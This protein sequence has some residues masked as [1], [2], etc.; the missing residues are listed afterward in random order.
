MSLLDSIRH[1]WNA[2]VGR[3]PTK[4]W[5][6]DNGE[7]SYTN[8]GRIVLT[9]GN[10]RSIITAVY[11]R[12]AVDA[13][14]ID[15]KH[16]KADEDGHFKSYI[17]DS[18]LNYLLEKSANLDQTGR[19]FRQSLFMQIL[20]DGVGVAV[21]VRTKE[22]PDITTGFKIEELRTGKITQWYP[23]RVKVE[24][25]DEEDG[26]KKEVIVDKK[27]TT[28]VEN[29]FYAIMNEKNSTLQRLIR[30]LNLLDIV[31]EASS[32]GK[33]DMIIQL[34]YAVK[35]ELQ[36]Q[37]AEE[38]TK[39]I[40]KQLKDGKYG[41]AYIDSTEHVT[42]LNR[43]LENKLMGQVEYLTNLL[44]SQLGITQE[45]MNGSAN[46]EAMNNYFSR[47][48]E[49]LVAAVCDEMERK[50]LSKT[51][52]SQ[53]HAILYFRD[54]FKLVP[55]SQ[56]A[57]LAN[58][59]ARNEIVTANEFRQIIGLKPSD[60]DK[61]DMLRNA[62]MPA[63]EGAPAEEIQNGGDMDAFSPDELKAQL[64]QLDDLDAQL[65]ELENM[66]KE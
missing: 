49:P 23:K 25:Y 38:R 64:Q 62:N 18:S 48:I 30:K 50:F 7:G 54:L 17:P 20:D 57:D 1:S 39:A 61:A 58:S 22:S 43:S 28:I 26:K 16:V 9:R 8:P 52:V 56:L 10:E 3:D 59:L 32:S 44:F 6:M 42:Q 55:L 60:E 41:V 29:P 63:E 51:A 53:G 12:M 14:T 45:I 5:G 35:S 36:M 37:R 34:P 33:L 2:F 11:T 27:W 66:S 4:T 47:T 31:D 40:E 15:I 21:P 13:A 24:V 46:E 65:D 19:A